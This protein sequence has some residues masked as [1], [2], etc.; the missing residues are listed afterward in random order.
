[1][2]EDHVATAQASID[3]PV[4]RV[5]N[6]LV[7][8][9]MIRR[10]MFGATVT[11]DWKRGSPITWSGE[12]QGKPLQDKGTILDIEP[13]ERLRV[14][15]YSPLSGRP[16]VP[17]DYHTVTYE[18]YAHEGHTHL[19]ISQDNNVDAKSAAHSE[20]MWTKMLTEL[21]RVVMESPHADA[22]E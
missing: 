3:A 12:W 7:D 21:S 18:L 14:S 22:A 9:A 15:H 5:W 16:D 8:P 6:A 20:Q 13:N 2:R 19:R 11:T 4:E 17:E 1:M 10:F